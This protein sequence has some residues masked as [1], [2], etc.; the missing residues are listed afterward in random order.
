MESPPAA[1]DPYVIMREGG[2]PAKAINPRRIT[3][4]LITS[5]AIVANYP[6]P[7]YGPPEFYLPV[8]EAPPLLGAFG[9]AEAKALLPFAPLALGAAAAVVGVFL[10]FGGSGD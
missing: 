4:D 8:P 5:E 10:A 9:L 2:I 1:P 7:S 6:A 3:G